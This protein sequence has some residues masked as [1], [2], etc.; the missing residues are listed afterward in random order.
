MKISTPGLL[1]RG[2]AMGIAE[3]IPGVSGGTI[4]FI[5]GIYKRLL[6]AITS[7]DGDFFQFIIN[8]KIRQ[9]FHHIDG[10]F[11]LR[12]LTGMTL[13]IIVGVFGVSY[14]LDTYPEV[15]WGLFFGLILGSIPYM[16]SQLKGRTV[17]YLLQFI[18]GAIIAY[19]VT[20]LVPAEGSES[21]VY[22]FFGGTLAICALVL[23]GISGSFIL[24]LLGLYS[25]VIPT[26]KNFLS[27]PNFSDLLLLGVFGLGCI[28]GLFFFSRIVSSAFNKYHDGTIA[29]LS[30]FMLGSLNKIWP[31]RNI[32]QV[33]EKES[34]NIM[35]YNQIDPNQLD[36]LYKILTDH[37]VS[38]SAYDGSPRII[39]VIGAFILGAV[40]IWLL[41]KCQTKIYAN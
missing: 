12:L 17:S 3:I 6:N 31:W 21:L 11:L 8:G 29:I 32:A 9:A 23:P 16:L 34:G 1:L 38:P 36:E 37:A 35:P 10:F 28:F 20:V 5:T 40:L 41:S 27:S 39:A 15:I 25:L 4:A 14:M 7:V 30:G 13:G 22:L 18:I 19:G 33:V 2:M 26:L 24:L